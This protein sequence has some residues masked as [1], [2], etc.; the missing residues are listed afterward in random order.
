MEWAKTTLKKAD[1]VVW[2]LQ[3]V[4][5]LLIDGRDGSNTADK[6]FGNYQNHNL[7]ELQDNL[8]HFYGH[9]SP[10]IDNYVFTKQTVGQ[11]FKDFTNLETEWQA[12]QDK[13]KPVTP[14]QRE[15]A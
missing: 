1:R 4:K 7:A 8:L 6:L 3:I 9:N 10:A 13:T 15:K 11:I 5:A 14:Q 2:Y 12:K